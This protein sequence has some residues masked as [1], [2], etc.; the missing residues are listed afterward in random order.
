[1][2]DTQAASIDFKALKIAK[3]KKQ[4]EEEAQ[5]KEQ[6]R[7]EKQKKRRK[8][9][10]SEEEEST[11]DAHD[12]TS[13]KEDSEEDSSDSSSDCD[14]SEFVS[15]IG[16]TTTTSGCMGL[17]MEGLRSSSSSRAILLQPF[18]EETILPT[19]DLMEK[20]SPPLP[21]KATCISYEDSEFL[22]RWF[23]LKD[24]LGTKLLTDTT[25]I[26]DDTVPELVQQT[27]TSPSSALADNMQHMKIVVSGVP[28]VVQQIFDDSVSAGRNI[29]ELWQETTGTSFTKQAVEEQKKLLEPFSKAAAVNVAE[30]SLYLAKVKQEKKVKAT[31]LP[32]KPEPEQTLPKTT[33][34][35]Y[36]MNS[37]G[38]ILID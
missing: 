17:N 16:P 13:K 27:P 4:E 23:G 34:F 8:I 24:Q 38:V 21:T 31:L 30:R 7:L 25:P 12:E 18:A 6:K 9:V 11:V 35:A 26:I 10:E 29:E 5:E 1:L 33:V 37:E 32:I 20:R 36:P 19:Q 22:R 28:E 15:P 3:K 14:M 2:L